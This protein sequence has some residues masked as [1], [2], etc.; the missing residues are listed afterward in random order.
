MEEF[1]V[2]KNILDWRYVWSI[3]GREKEN[4]Y[5]MNVLI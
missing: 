3:C 5:V 1:E 4:R 2:I